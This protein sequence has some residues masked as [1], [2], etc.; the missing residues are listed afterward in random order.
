[1]RLILWFAEAYQN[2]NGTGLRRRMLY[3]PGIFRPQDFDNLRG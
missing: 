2:D 1:M 3:E